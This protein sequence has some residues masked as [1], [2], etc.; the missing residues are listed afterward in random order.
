M[1]H[2]KEP[3][4]F[5]RDD[6]EWRGEKI[7][8]YF[9]APKGKLPTFAHIY[10]YPGK[11]KANAQR[12]VDCVNGCAGI[13]NPGAVGKL[14]EASKKAIGWLETFENLGTGMKGQNIALEQTT[15]YLRKTINNIQGINP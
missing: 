2:T 10:N 14:L 7:E 4:E 12:I 13:E 1:Q 6:K 5:W 9:I 11:T 8:A 3:W 15:D